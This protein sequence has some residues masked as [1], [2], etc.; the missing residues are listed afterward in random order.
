MV[1][2]ARRNVVE[3][4]IVIPEQV[5]GPVD[6]HLGQVMTEG[7]AAMRLEQPRQMIGGHA[8]LLGHGVARDFVLIMALQKDADFFQQVLGAT[9]GLDNWLA[10][11]SFHAVKQAA[12]QVG[13]GR[14]GVVLAQQFVER[15]QQMRHRAA[16]G[17]GQGIFFGSQLRI[18][19]G[20]RG[21]NANAQLGPA[22]KNAQQ[23]QPRLPLGQVPAIGR[24]K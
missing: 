23:F 2:A 13:E 7:H 18:V 3:L 4:Q 14:A 5:L 6:P 10:Q 1:T 9:T 21:D 8:E 20:S 22:K 17:P 16:N 11:Q 12:G 19:F 15:G 24:R